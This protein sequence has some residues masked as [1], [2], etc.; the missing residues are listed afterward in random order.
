M[1]GAALRLLIVLPLVTA[2]AYFFIKYGL[3]RR[4]RVINGSRRMRI[5]EQLPI[6]PKAFLTLV[7]V[8]GSYL[9]LAQHEKGVSVLEHMDD[10]P[11]PVAPGEK[12]IDFKE[13]LSAASKGINLLSSRVSKYR[14]RE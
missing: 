4:S 10:L 8:G 6:G 3:A 12:D 1:I 2:M 14:S 9:L 5:I 7:E 13:I 11:N